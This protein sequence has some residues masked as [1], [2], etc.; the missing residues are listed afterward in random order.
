MDPQAT[1]DLSS[2]VAS[3]PLVVYDHGEQPDNYHTMLSVAAG[4]SHT[5]RIP[6]LQNSTCLQ[7]PC[8]L[9]L[10]ADNTTPSQCCL[11]NPQTG[12]KISLPAM[13]A[14][15]PEGSGCLLSDTVSSPDCLVLINDTT[16]FSFTFCH[17]RGRTAWT[18]QPYDVGFYAQPPGSLAAPVRMPIKNL[19]AVQGKFYFRDTATDEVSV[20]SFVQDPE[21][22]LEMT[23][24]HALRLPFPSVSGLPQLVTVGYLL[25]SSG[26]LFLVCIYMP[27]C[28]FQHVEEV[29]AYKMDFSKQEW[30]E[31]FNIGDRAFLL[32]PRSFA[33][34]CAAEEHGLKS[35]CVY[36]AYDFFGNTNEIC[37]FHLL[38]GTR[39]LI[40][41]GQDVPLPA[42][43]PFWMLPVCS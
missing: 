12:E 26:E 39:E 2:L 32:G 43:R 3:F 42:R 18:V 35:S 41:P 29:C 8:G 38:E 36:F 21:P 20:L 16:G 40:D 10:V 33:A 27:G 25:E 19:A 1:V 11:W 28:D 13:D 7:T 17:V 34:S 22:H 24:F 14:P 5:C 37:I 15:P 30:C 9:V 4:S 6:E 23:S 31:V